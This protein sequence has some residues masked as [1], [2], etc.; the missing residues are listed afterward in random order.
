V[1]DAL[2]PISPEP[3]DAGRA[4][5]KAG[6]GS[7]V[8]C[9]K[10][11]WSGYPVDSIK[12]VGQ[13]RGFAAVGKPPLWRTRTES[14][15]FRF[16][17]TRSRF[18]GEGGSSAPRSRLACSPART[19][20]ASPA[21]RRRRDFKRSQFPVRA[22]TTVSYAHATVENKLTYSSLIEVGSIDDVGSIDGGVSSLR[23]PRHDE[24]ALGGGHP[25]A[26]EVT[27]GGICGS[28]MLMLISG[29]Q[30]TG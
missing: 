30:R 2:R 13:T 7:F 24:V 10:A 1:G 15:P 28:L 18:C 4:T 9:E 14:R 20:P 27:K 11:I 17:G 29:N 6:S 3:V 25:A 5:R 16:S 8:S 19:T 26:A 21:Q 12:P 22:A 23:R